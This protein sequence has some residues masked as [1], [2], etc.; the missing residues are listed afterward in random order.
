MARIPTYTSKRTP[1]SEP[2]RVYIK[3][4][5]YAEEQSPELAA[6]TSFG[7]SMEKAGE[8]VSKVS[9]KMIAIQNANSESEANILTTQGFANYEDEVNKRTDLNKALED[10]PNRISKIKQEGADRFTDPR[11]RA[12]WERN[13]DLKAIVYE[14]QLR[15][16]VNKKQVDLGRTNT[17]REIDLELTNYI[18]S[19]TPEAKNTSKENME[20]IMGRASNLGL[21]T[22][23]QGYKL[24]EDTVSKGE[25]I[26]NDTKK[27]AE[28]KEK[29]LLQA[30]KKAV[31]Q[32]ENEYINM[33][34]NNKD[35]FGNFISDADLIK[36]IGSDTTV[37]EDFKKAYV[38][39]ITNPAGVESKSNP[40]TLD[41][42]LDKILT[43]GDDMQST[44][45]L[46]LLLE[47]SKPKPSLSWEDYDMLM[48]FNDIVNNPDTM[49]Q[50]VP[51]KGF[52]KS[53]DKWN[54]E[55]AG[56]KSEIKMEMFRSYFNKVQNGLAPE[57]AAKQTIEEEM[58]KLNPDIKTYPKEGK[59]VIDKDGII[60]ILTPDYLI[61]DPI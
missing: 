21:F 34:K 23:E 12:E 15:A 24:V 8:I 28:R 9:E 49:N 58:L 32:A 14:N 22:K 52:W 10:A 7:A 30:Q 29:E 47:M 1:T 19:P 50:F 41:K 35:K 18:N 51:A 61:K 39:A 5:K 27:L 17:L 42:F 26:I 40:K 2:Q 37:S 59:K 54:E 53:V 44:N 43:F 46:N 60:K 4:A 13:F 6:K 20:A 57:E 38:S 16:G 56:K 36:M 48:G 55:N 33:K 45:R 31:N 3:P 25:G 11:A